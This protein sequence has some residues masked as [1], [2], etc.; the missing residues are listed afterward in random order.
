[1]KN[2]GVLPDT[3]AWI[4]YFKPGSSTLKQTLERLLLDDDVF[5]CG[6]VL[7]ELAQVLKSDKE[8]SSVME[9]LNS[10]EYIETSQD[11]WM[12]AGE[13]SSSLRK[14]GK[15]LPFSDI[16]IAA[17]AIENNLSILTVDKHFEEIKGVNIYPR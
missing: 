10:L 1:M 16:L 9:A 12:K 4:E 13:L 14:E 6:P 15:T 3:C 17:M 2:R 8:K 7:Y 11:L 5:V